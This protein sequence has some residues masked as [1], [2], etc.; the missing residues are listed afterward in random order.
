[1]LKLHVVKEAIQSSSSLPFIRIPTLISV[2]KCKNIWRDTVPIMRTRE[3][4]LFFLLNDNRTVILSRQDFFPDRTSDGALF[5]VYSLSSYLKFGSRHEDSSRFYR[6]QGR[7][8]TRNSRSARFKNGFS[9]VKLVSEVNCSKSSN[10]PDIHMICSR[11]SLKRLK[12]KHKSAISTLRIIAKDS[13]K[14]HYD[15]MALSFSKRVAP[16]W[17]NKPHKS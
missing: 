5:V 17:L 6:K 4:H 8:A 15:F 9:N 2:F 12:D 14:L 16:V 3:R 11:S 13:Q 10:I 7:P 1:M